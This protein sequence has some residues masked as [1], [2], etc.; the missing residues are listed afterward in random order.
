MCGSAHA[1]LQAMPPREPPLP[2]AIPLIVVLG[3][4]AIICFAIDDLYHL[5]RRTVRQLRT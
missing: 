5:I 3:L 1:R 2:V 4:L